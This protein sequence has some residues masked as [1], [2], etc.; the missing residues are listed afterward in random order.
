MSLSYSHRLRLLTVYG[1][2]YHTLLGLLAWMPR[3]KHVFF[4]G[5]AKT[6]I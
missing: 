5:D 3:F 4:Y 1:E 2:L 6:V